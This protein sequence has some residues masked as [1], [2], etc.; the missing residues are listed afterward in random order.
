MNMHQKTHGLSRKEII[1]LLSC[2]IIVVKSLGLKKVERD[3]AVVEEKFQREKWTDA[4]DIKGEM[5]EQ[6]RD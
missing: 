6:D 1:C 3:C 5:E 4:G 2:S